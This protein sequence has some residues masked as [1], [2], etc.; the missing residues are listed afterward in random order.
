VSNRNRLILG[1]CAWLGLWTTAGNL[2]AQNLGARQSLRDWHAPAQQRRSGRFLARRGVGPRRRYSR[3]AAEM[4][5]EARAQ[6]RAM[7]VQRDTSGMSTP[8]TAPW[9]SLGPAQVMTSAFGA[10]TG[11][12]SSIASDPSDPTGNIVYVGT[13]GGGVWKS[14]NAAGNLAQVSF[15]PLTDTLGAYAGASTASLSI[16]SVT[17]QPGGTGVVLAGTG[18]PNDATDSYYGAGILRSADGGLTWSLIANSSD[19]SIGGVT[20][21][22]FQGNG[23]AGFAWSTSNP[24][25]VVAAVSQRPRAWRSAL[26]YREA[27]SWGSITPRMPGRHGISRRSPTGSRVSCSR[28]RRTLRP[29]AMRR[30]QWCGIRYGRCSM[31]R[32]V[33]MGITSRRTES[34]G[35]GWQTSRGVR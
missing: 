28:T 16:G 14:V 15:T 22:K 27:A 24:N 20:N 26:P 9:Q 6:H 21:F 3:N 33:F 31:P 7:V 23:F 32:C 13:T 5:A 25:L 8:L 12:V 10:V 1:L 30:R 35:R 17:V 4:L 18:D 2:H 19:H 11:R 29:T 34:T